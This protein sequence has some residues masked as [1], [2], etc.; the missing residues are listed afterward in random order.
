[1]RSARGWR[2][3]GSSPLTR[4][5]RLALL[6]RRLESRLIP[7]HAGKTCRGSVKWPTWRAHPHSRGENRHDPRFPVRDRGSSPLTRGK[8]AVNKLFQ[9]GEGL[10]PTHAGKTHQL[11]TPQ[12]PERAHPRSRGENHTARRGDDHVAGSSPL[13]RGKPDQLHRADH[14]R[15]LIPA[16]AGKTF[17]GNDCGTHC[18]AHPRS[19]GE[20]RGGSR[21]RCCCPGSSPLTRGK[22]RPRCPCYP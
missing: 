9:F 15:R 2:V 18:S 12:Q 7:T 19:R 16:H 11:P 13:T 10:I 4:G 17:C 5:K 21:C 14:A 6:H 3:G 20:N 1:M 22:H 8:Q